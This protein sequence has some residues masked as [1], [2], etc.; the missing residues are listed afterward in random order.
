[1]DKQQ[2]RRRGIRQYRPRRRDLG[3]V[4]ELDGAGALATNDDPDHARAEAHRTAALGESGRH[5]L[6]QALRAPGGDGEAPG[7]RGQREHVTERRAQRIV[8]PD[9]DVQTKAGQHAPR[10][11]TLEQAARQP[12]R[13]AGQQARDLEQIADAEAQQRPHRWKR[14]KEHREELGFD[15]GVKARQVRERPGVARAAERRRPDRVG[16]GD[17][18]DAS[19]ERWMAALVGGA[20]PVDASARQIQP[21]E[22]RAAGGKRKEPR[23]KVVPKTRQR[24]LLGSERAP[25]PARVCLEH[26]HPESTAGHAIGGAEAVGPGADHHHLWIVHAV[27]NLS[28]N[29]GSE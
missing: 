26:Q 29:R 23:P 25:C 24:Q 17:D 22:G 2:R 16:A 8:G 4:V 15:A 10:R 13:A 14:A 21:D 6:D 18:S 12:A 9:I 3:A 1:M 5:R 20:A 7:G 19:V 11:L 28:G 27:R